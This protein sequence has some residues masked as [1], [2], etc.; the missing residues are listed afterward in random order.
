MEIKMDDKMVS[1]RFSDKL[2]KLRHDRDWSQGQVAKKL[3]INTQRV[4]KYE[5]GVITPPSDM[6][7]KIASVYDVSL[8]YLLREAPDTAVS[9]IKNQ[10]LLK[11][12]EEIND[13]IKLL[14]EPREIA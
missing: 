6:M 8:D 7:V 4:S 11:R 12:I 1:K 3:G 14:I 9:R 2:K 10:A 5:R 13:G